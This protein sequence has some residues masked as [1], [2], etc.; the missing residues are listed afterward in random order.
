MLIIVIII[1]I[2]LIILLIIDSLETFEEEEKWFK[3]WLID[4]ENMTFFTTMNWIWAQKRKKI[5]EGGHPNII[6]FPKL[7]MVSIIIDY[8]GD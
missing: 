8:N 7:V 4:M 3:C 5:E 1:P 2:L 6:H